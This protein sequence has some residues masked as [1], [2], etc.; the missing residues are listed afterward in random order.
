[1][2]S[3][4]VQ[5][6]GNAYPQRAHTLPTCFVTTQPALTGA[7]GEC[8]VQLLSEKTLKVWPPWLYY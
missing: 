7:T 2:S 1:M 6:E 3:S 4:G 8:W 5:T